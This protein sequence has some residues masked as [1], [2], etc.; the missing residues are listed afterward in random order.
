MR[1][2]TCDECIH[3]LIRRLFQ[4]AARSARYDANAA[5]DGWTSGN[6]QRLGAGSTPQTAGQIVSRQGLPGLKSEELAVIEEERLQLSQAESSAKP[7]VIA[8]SRMNIERQMGAI[9]GEVVLQEQAMVVEAVEEPLGDRIVVA[10]AMPHTGLVSS[11]EMDA[12]HQ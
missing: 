1:P 5:A 6:D 12:K 9:D 4:L 11:A 10:F 8:K 3:A 7:R 2:F